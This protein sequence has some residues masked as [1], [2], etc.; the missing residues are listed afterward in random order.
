[1]KEKKCLILG[2]HSSWKPYDRIM[3]V[4]LETWASVQVEGTE[5]ILYCDGNKPNT[6]KVIYI[7]VPTDIF[8]I[9]YK[10]LAAFEWALKNKDFDYISR[11]QA[12]GYIHKK[13]LIKYIQD[14]PD[15]NVFAALECVGPPRYRWGVAYLLSR[16]VIQK[17][18]DNKHL[19]DHKKMEDVAMSDLADKLGVPYLQ[20]KACSIDKVSDGLWQCTSYGSESFQFT[21][22]EDINKA[23]GQYWFRCKQDYDRTK[24]EYVMR[25]LFKHLK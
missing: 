22:F 11:P 6:D 21:S 23:T 18:V 14:L 2:I 5:T 16:D 7:D 17:L 25:E 10:T 12:N 1:M 20:G 24:D 8:S 15:N 13:E 19:W 4:A 9:G 3:Q